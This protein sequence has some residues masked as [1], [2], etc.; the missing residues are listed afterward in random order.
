[1]LYDIYIYIYVSLG[2]LRLSVRSVTFV[3]TKVLPRKPLVFICLHNA[4]QTPM[5]RIALTLLVLE[6]SD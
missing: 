4:F 2:G 1:M 5:L 3:K 6:C